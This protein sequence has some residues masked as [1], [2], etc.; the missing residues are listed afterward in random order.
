MLNLVK[1]QGK[2]N[3]RLQKYFDDLLKFYKTFLQYSLALSKS[4]VSNNSNVLWA[5]IYI[6]IVIS[7]NQSTLLSAYNNCTQLKHIMVLKEKSN[8]KKTS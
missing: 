8:C 6:T 5:P 4:I 3:V 1:K 2:M 7:Q